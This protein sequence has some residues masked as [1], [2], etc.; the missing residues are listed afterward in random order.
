MMSKD[1]HASSCKELSMKP[2]LQ[3]SEL[4]LDELN[5]TKRW[6]RLLILEEELAVPTIPTASVQKEN[7]PVPTSQ[8]Q[9]NKHVFFVFSLKD[10][11]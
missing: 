5:D 6:R 8:N 2:H 1:L 4:D 3:L 7:P 9:S 11:K 10:T